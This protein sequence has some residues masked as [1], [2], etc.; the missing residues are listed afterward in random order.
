MGHLVKAE[1]DRLPAGEVELA[2]VDILHLPQIAPLALYASPHGKLLE[3]RDDDH[4][5][6]DGDDDLELA[7]TALQ[8]ERAPL[9]AGLLQAAMGIAEGA[10]ELFL[11][12]AALIHAIEGMRGDPVAPVPRASLEYRRGPRR[13]SPPH[14]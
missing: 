3:H 14:I 13:A 4:P 1:W 11:R 6:F 8:S 5:V 9:V 10:H 7:P 2:V 12:D